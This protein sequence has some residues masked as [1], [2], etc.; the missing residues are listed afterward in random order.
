[1]S[2]LFISDLHLDPQR[3]AI[4]QA[5]YHFL[6]TTAQ[7][8]EALYIL[9]DLFEVWLGD[10]D[11]TPVY[12]DVIQRIRAYKN[13]GSDV[14]FMRGNRDF[15]IGNEFS[16]R[17]G[18]T[19]LNDPTVIDYHHHHL[20][21]MHGDSLCTKDSDYMQFREMTRAPQWQE[22][23]LSTPLSERRNYAN[24]VRKK[25]STMN[26]LKAEDIMDVTHEDVVR[27]M[28]EHKVSTLIH[29]HTHRPNKHH[30]LIDNTEAQRFVLGDWGKQAWYIQADKATISLNSLDI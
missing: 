11:D 21:L 14:Y 8:A 2:L 6:D 13:Q 29:G 4:T 30:L 3:P 23:L 9:G 28:A 1:M 12:Q 16:R 26:S 18:A 7:N 10:D 25:S 24:E 19:L 17:S 22:K 20:L 27:T 15:L 5:F